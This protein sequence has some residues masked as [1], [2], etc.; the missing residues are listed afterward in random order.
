MGSANWRAAQLKIAK[1]HTK[2]ANIH[3]DVL[4]KLTTYLAKS[5]ANQGFYE[6]RR[7]LEYKTH[8]ISVRYT[9]ARYNTS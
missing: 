3:H 9:C 7:Q 1:L 5:I 6:F 8:L 2:V 4:H